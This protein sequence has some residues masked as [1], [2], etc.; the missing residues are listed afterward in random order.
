MLF[1]H[2]ENITGKKRKG[3]EV[4]PTSSSSPG[5]PPMAP[6]A[7]GALFPRRRTIEGDDALRPVNMRGFLFGE[8]PPPPPQGAGAGSALAAA[9][10]MG[11]PRSAIPGPRPHASDLAMRNLATTGA[12]SNE[13]T[14]PPPYASAVSSSEM[15]SIIT[16]LAVTAAADNI[17]IPPSPSSPRYARRSSFTLGGENRNVPY[18]S[19]LSSSLAAPHNASSPNLLFGSTS[20]NLFGS[21]NAN[22]E[23]EQASPSRSGAPSS[24]SPPPTKS[25]PKMTI[26]IHRHLADQHFFG[27]P[28]VNDDNGNMTSGSISMDADFFHPTWDR[29]G[30]VRRNGGNGS[31]HDTTANN[32]N[33]NGGVT[34]DNW[35]GGGWGTHVA[36]VLP[37]PPTPP[38]D[39]IGETVDQRF[40][41]GLGPAQDAAANL[42]NSSRM[43]NE[44]Y[45][46]AVRAFVNWTLA[47]ATDPAT[48]N[49]NNIHAEAVAWGDRLPPSVTNNPNSAAGRLHASTWADNLGGGSGFGGTPQP[50][51]SP[52]SDVHLEV[53]SSAT[54]SSGNAPLKSDTEEDRAISEAVT[55]MKERNERYLHK[56]DNILLKSSN[57]GNN[58]NAISAAR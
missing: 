37:N 42:S 11:R 55:K 45:R 35:D 14:A 2:C 16:S 6:Q 56:L 7:R 58:N 36:A 49:N 3:I 22:S 5:I 38:N 32:Q 13:R 52:A 10:A 39:N 46:A 24:P 28:N 18:L 50:Y 33:D 43:H 4:D 41:A 54:S 23:W 9:S 53:Y 34:T 51:Y 26:K 25:H 1:P 44:N 27:S 19:P 21:P 31:H 57:S 8:G 47:N 17:G 12:L 48:R 30:R 15:T 20:P 29:Y 40:A